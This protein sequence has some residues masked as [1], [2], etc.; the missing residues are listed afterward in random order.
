MEQIKHLETNSCIY[1]TSNDENDSISNQWKRNYLKNK[2]GYPF[3]E[4]KKLY[5]K[6][7][8][9]VKQKKNSTT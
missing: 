7:N 9:K 8:N 3:V 2:L 1:N 6:V 4:N 5:T